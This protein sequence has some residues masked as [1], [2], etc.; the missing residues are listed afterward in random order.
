MKALWLLAWRNLWRNRRRTLLQVLAISGAVYLS[1]CFENLA[2]GE[3][4]DI[5]RMGVRTGSGH[6]AVYRKGYLEERKFKLHFALGPWLDSLKALPEVEGVFPRLY[7]P[8]LARS[9]RTNRAAMIIALEREDMAT[10]PFLQ[11]SLRGSLPGVREA[12]VGK[13]L[14]EALGLEK[15]RKFVVVLQDFEGELTSLLFRV[16]GVVHTGVPELDRG[17]VFVDR[18][19]LASLLGDGHQV[20]EVAIM[21]RKGVR[22]PRLLAKVQAVLPEADLEAVRWEEAMPELKSG[23]AMDHSNLIL[24]NVLIFL[25]VAVGT[26]NVMFMSALERV[27]EWGILRALGLRRGTVLRLVLAEGILLGAVGMLV[28]SALTILTTVITGHTGVDFRWMMGETSSVSFAGIAWEPVV[29]PRMNWT[30]LA[31]YCGAVV[32]LSLLGGLFPARWAA[33]LKPAE[34]LRR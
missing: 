7:A 5:I 24:M 27:R 18:T 6:V 34:A 16:S 30:I 19:F 25:I 4:E 10:H 13:D 1:T 21:A 31:L 8:G 15:G 32:F 22:V 9:F 2:M 23:I 26:L 33:S 14:A 11:K 3:Y 28:G 29:Y 12:V 20:H 17:A